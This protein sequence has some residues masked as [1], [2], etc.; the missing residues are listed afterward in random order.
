MKAKK[1]VLIVTASALVLVALAVNWRFSLLNGL[2]SGNEPEPSESL[3]V[4]ATV[5]E[6]YFD[7]ARYSRTQSREQAVALLN[8]V[9]NDES[10]EEEVRANAYEQVVCYARITEGEASLES[11][12]LAKGFEDCVVYLTEDTATVVVAAQELDTN[13]ATQILD[14]VLAQTGLDAGCVKIVAY[15]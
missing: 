10:V 4:S 9:I 8:S 15:P 1:T 11:I 3:P 5:E 7:R 12:L 13:A 6:T 14:A 2:F